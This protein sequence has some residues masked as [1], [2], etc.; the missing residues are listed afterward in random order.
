MI[1]SSLNA[2]FALF[3]E[4]NKSETFQEDLFNESVLMTLSRATSIDSNINP[5]EVSRVREIVSDLTNQ[6]VSDSDV[7]VAAN[8][9]IY[10]EGSLSRFLNAVSLKLSVKHKLSLVNALA[11]V[12]KADHRVTEREVFFFNMV[13][14][15][16]NIRAS[17]LVEL[18]QTQAF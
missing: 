15:D 6:D 1:K 12:I 5:V 7:R 18:E 11:D 16:L 4:T 8:S 13:V 17:D 9:Q 3:D 2:I 10:E 14:S